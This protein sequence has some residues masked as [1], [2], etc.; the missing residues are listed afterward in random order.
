MLLDQ[1]NQ[2]H[3]LNSSNMYFGELF[4][5][6]QSKTA[7]TR[8]SDNDITL[9]RPRLVNDL[10]NW[11]RSTKFN[12]LCLLLGETDMPLLRIYA[13]IPAFFNPSPYNLRI[14]KILRIFQ[15]SAY[16]KKTGSRFS[17]TSYFFKNIIDFFAICLCCC[18]QDT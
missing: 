7:I 2:T 3:L 14:Q 13:E 16:V 8:R 9:S 1:T 12:R 4:F 10:K 18:Q 11:S 15:K 17:R 6:I 5:L